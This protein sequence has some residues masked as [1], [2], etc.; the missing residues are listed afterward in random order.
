MERPPSPHPNKI[1]TI[2]EN[3]EINAES[4]VEQPGVLERLLSELNAIRKDIKEIKRKLQ[5]NL[6]L[7]QI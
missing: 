4:T 2:L 1:K 5:D 7:T 6:N 3:Y